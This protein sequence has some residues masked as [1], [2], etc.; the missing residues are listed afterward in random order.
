MRALPTL[1]PFRTRWRDLTG[2]LA[3]EG[4]SRHRLTVPHR[5]ATLVTPRSVLSSHPTT[6]P[7]PRSNPKPSF[8][9]CSASGPHSQTL[10]FTHS[11]VFPDFRERLREPAPRAFRIVSTSC[12]SLAC[13]SSFLASYY[14]RPL[15][16]ASQQQTLVRTIS[17]LAAR[18]RPRATRLLIPRLLRR[19]C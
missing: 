8:Q 9:A 13:V 19:A 4:S 16:Q 3:L 18:G 6:N 10:S 17:W 12:H 14:S 7:H 11:L 1:P 5:I 15:L 2:S